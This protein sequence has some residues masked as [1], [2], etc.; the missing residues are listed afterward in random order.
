MEKL[1]N[2]EN[3]NLERHWAKKEQ[4]QEKVVIQNDIQWL[5]LPYIY[6]NLSFKRCYSYAI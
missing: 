4:N 6:G 1:N 5:T 3:Y 2:E